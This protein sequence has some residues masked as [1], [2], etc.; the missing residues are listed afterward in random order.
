MLKKPIYSCSICGEPPVTSRRIDD[1]AV[2]WHCRD[3]LE[4]DERVAFDALVAEGWEAPRP[5]T[6]H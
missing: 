2:V 6:I 3:H 1:G 4:A 5:R